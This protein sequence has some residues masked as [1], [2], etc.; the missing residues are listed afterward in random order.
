MPRIYE[1]WL[2]LTPFVGLAISRQSMKIIET[3]RKQRSANKFQISNTVVGKTQKSHINRMSY[4]L[5]ENAEQYDTSSLHIDQTAHLDKN[6]KE[7]HRLISFKGDF[8]LL[9]LIDG[10]KKIVCFDL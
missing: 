4:C 5:I 2:I 3:D 1:K 9:C 8:F 10:L 6:L 7:R